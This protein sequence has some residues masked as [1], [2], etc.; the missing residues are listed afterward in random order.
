MAIDVS[1]RSPSLDVC[2]GDLLALNSYSDVVAKR[3]LTV[4]LDPEVARATRVHAART[5]QPD[6]QVVEEALRRLL[7]I[8]ALDEAHGLSTWDED[9]AMEIANAEVHAYRR[10]R[11]GH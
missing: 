1:Q 9:A 10:E 3:K 8:T 11:P 4:Y 2:T 5:D 7:G 6:S